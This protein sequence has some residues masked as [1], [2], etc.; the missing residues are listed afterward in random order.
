MARFRLTRPLVVQLGPHAVTTMPGPD[1]VVDTATL[2]AT[3]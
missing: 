2:P 1:A 3:F